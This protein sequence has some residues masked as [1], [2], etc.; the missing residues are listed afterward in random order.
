MED[1]V[2]LLSNKHKVWITPPVYLTRPIFCYQFTM[3]KK[4]CS[5]ILVCFVGSFV[6]ILWTYYFRSLQTSLN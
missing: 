1:F 3:P 6:F 4:T 2:S 5:L